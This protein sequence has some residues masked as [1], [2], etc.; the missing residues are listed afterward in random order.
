M[1]KLFSKGLRPGSVQPLLTTQG[2]AQILPP[3]EG[4]RNDW[5]GTEEQYAQA[6]WESVGC[7]PPPP[8]RSWSLKSG[9]NAEKEKAT[10]ERRVQV[11]AFAS[12]WVT[13]FDIMDKFGVCRSTVFLDIGFMYEYGMLDERPIKSR[14]HYIH[15]YKATP[16]AAKHGYD[17][18]VKR[19]KVDRSMDEPKP[20]KEDRMAQ[21][22]A[23]LPASKARIAK[24]MGLSEWTISKYALHMLDKVE[25]YQDFVGVRKVTHFRL[26]KK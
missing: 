2:H 26:I 7:K 20:T 1:T 13:S 11:L 6:M 19:G 23:M 16:Y 25:S 18:C 22:V 14:N 10:H 21:M 17:G 5:T 3:D 8:M 12:D 4:K 24:E 15:Q 9:R